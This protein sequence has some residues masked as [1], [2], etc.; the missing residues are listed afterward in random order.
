MFYSC[1]KDL[2]TNSSTLV[3]SES[4]PI[5]ANHHPPPPVMGHTLW[6]F[7]EKAI[8]IFYYCILDIGNASFLGV[9]TF[10]FPRRNVEFCYV[11]D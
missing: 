8:Y 1:F 3:I 6:P 9:W 5:V 2:F 4:V 11:S 7:K 10:F